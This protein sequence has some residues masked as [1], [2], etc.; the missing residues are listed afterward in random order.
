[1]DL[2][3]SHL[4]PQGSKFGAWVSHCKMPQKPVACRAAVPKI[5]FEFVSCPALANGTRRCAHA[6]NSILLSCKWR[7]EDKVPKK[8]HRPP[9]ATKS[10]Q[11]WAVEWKANFTQKI[12]VL[13]RPSEKLHAFA[14]HN[15]AN[16]LFNNFQLKPHTH[17]N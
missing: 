6:L 11:K 12:L 9:V 5:Q 13:K 17:E 3:F 8:G 7:G 16:I 1:M 4:H 2:K 10:A 14:V 15:C